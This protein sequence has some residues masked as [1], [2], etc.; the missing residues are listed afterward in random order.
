MVMYVDVEL[1]FRAHMRGTKRDVRNSRAGLLPRIESA[2][3][4][5]VTLSFRDGFIYKATVRH[6]MYIPVHLSERKEI[7]WLTER[8][9]DM[10]DVKPPFNCTVR[11][12]VTF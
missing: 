9:D 5:S 10:L 7:Y 12:N 6:F 8:G 11:Q 4:S 1:V 2:R 3:S